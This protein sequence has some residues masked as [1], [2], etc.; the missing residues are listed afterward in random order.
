MERSH[1]SRLTILFIYAPPPRAEFW[2]GGG[3]VDSNCR[4]TARRSW[5]QTD[6]GLSARFHGA[7]MGAPP[8]NSGFPRKQAWLTGRKG[9]GGLTGPGK[10][11]YFG[12][13]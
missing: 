9:G 10:I 4:L 2:G 11:R 13:K 6:R 1:I 7:S 3:A 12:F 8:E 5:A